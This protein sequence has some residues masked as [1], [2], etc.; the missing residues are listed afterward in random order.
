MRFPVAPKPT[1]GIRGTGSAIRAAIP[2][3]AVLGL[4]L[5]LLPSPSSLQNTA[6]GQREKLASVPE[7]PVPGIFP[8]GDNRGDELFSLLPGAAM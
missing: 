8:S 7:A 3:D 4:I 5:L 6:P 2:T 1:D